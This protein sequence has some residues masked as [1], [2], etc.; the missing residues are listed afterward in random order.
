M[1]AALILA[2]TALCLGL[3]A[4]SQAQKPTVTASRG[5]LI[6]QG[7]GIVGIQGAITNTSS[8]ILTITADTITVVNGSVNEDFIQYTDGFTNANLPL[9]INPNSSFVGFTSQNASNRDPNNNPLPGVGTTPYLFTVVYSGSGMPTD[10]STGSV[11]LSYRL[12]TNPF[13]FTDR[14]IFPAAPPPPLTPEPG[15]M[16]LMGSGLVSGGLFLAR[17]RRRK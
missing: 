2:S 5:G 14:F 9:V 1:K 12:G 10:P 15:M 13:V 8:D 6:P 16:A 17:R 7:G 3:A 11:Q 4:S